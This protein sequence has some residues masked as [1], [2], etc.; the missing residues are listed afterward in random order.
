MVNC[1]NCKGLRYGKKPLEPA[2]IPPRPADLISKKYQIAAEIIT[3]LGSKGESL[4]SIEDALIAN[5]FRRE[6]A[7]SAMA[8]YRVI[9]KQIKESKEK[10]VFQGSTTTF[11]DLV[12]ELK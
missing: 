2:P 8:F 11:D 1:E 9:A 5:G 7:K 6:E 4:Q 10:D 3:D 12:G